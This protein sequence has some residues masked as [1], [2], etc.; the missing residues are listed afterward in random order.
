[1]RRAFRHAVASRV[2]ARAAGP[3]TR[4]A[5]L[6]LALTTLPA[7]SA[8]PALELGDR[9][10]I[11]GF[12]AEFDSSEAL[13]GINDEFVKD[14]VRCVLGGFPA[15]PPEES[16]QDSQWGFFNDVNQIHVTW[17]SKF[18]YVA[19]DGI[20]WGNNLMLFF[21]VT[22][23]NRTD[24]GAGLPDL[25]NVN[26]WRRNLS[27]ANDFAP[28]FFLATWDGNA[29]PQIWTYQ[30]TRTVSQ[31]PA[32]S[33]STAATFSNNAQ[34]RAMEAAI[35]WS[36]VFQRDSVVVSS[37]YGDTVPVIP[38][39]FEELRLLACLTAGGDGTGSPDS[40]PDNFSGHQVD[41]NAAA[42]LDNFV[43]LPLDLLDAAGQPNPDGVP[44]MP[45]AGA[46]FTVDVAARR[47]FLQRPPIAGISFSL[48]D[49]VITQGVVSPEQGRDLEFRVALDQRL[50]V[51][52]GEGRSV[53]LTAEIYD[54]R[55]ERH[56]LLYHNL[57]IPAIDL[58]QFE[59]NRWDGRD[60]RGR[61][62][63]GGI[64]ILRIV[65]EPGQDQ[66]RRSFAVVR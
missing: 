41:G 50:S 26:A 25:L 5:G 66:V 39:G 62:V 29:T 37:A 24:L 4:L 45:G 10:V 40:A 8:G 54:L 6:A 44:D 60:A 13:F 19:V 46:T 42:L 27:F 43:I 2:A 23:R 9:I 18:L 51:E 61:M 1:M 33:F 34:G 64:Y 63:E 3:I 35:P 49:I 47:T 32:A 30:N 38:R 15:C 59:G 53:S 17:D 22:R 28:D 56:R 65:L 16:V 21:D 57:R 12:S 58:P 36:L 11:D 48:A 31:V 55:G 14:G 52:S 20:T 7:A